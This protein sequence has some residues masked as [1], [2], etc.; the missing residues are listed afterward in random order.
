[1]NAWLI[2]KSALDVV[3]AAEALGVI[4]TATQQAEFTA[5]YTDGDYPGARIM[6]K[7]GNVAQINISG[8]L[9]KEPSWVLRWFGGGNTAYSEII[10]AINEA[11]R[12]PAIEEVVFAIDS[13]GGQTSGLTGAMDAIAAMTMP[14][15]AEV[16]GM[17]ASA[18]YGLASQADSI[19]ATDRGAMFGSIGVKATYYVDG[20]V[21]EVTSSNAP[22]KAPDVTTEEGR[23]MV[24]KL[25]D[26]IEAVF[27]ED[28]ARGRN[29][30]PDKVKADFGRGGVFLAN[31][32]KTHGMIDD[33]KD[34]TQQPGATTTTQEAN[35]M[36]LQELQQKHPETY[37]AA[38]AEGVAQGIAQEKDRVSAH[39]TAGEACGD[40]TIAVAAVN[41]GSQF[42][43]AHQSKYMV[44]GMKNSQIGARQGDTTTTDAALTGVTPGAGV[45]DTSAQDKIFLDALGVQP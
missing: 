9:S 12:D 32:A 16:S 22:E 4:P 40:L 27:I 39:L 3:R 37:A 35:S 17:A 6:S 19:T 11:E 41:D 42:T 29:T 5:S 31:E 30:T 33:V 20:T 43:Q 10:S 26:Q 7:V 15:R 36:N 8:V 18:A 13:P 38:V 1:M 34:R 25:L 44:A 28:I 45:T 2:T 24:Q 14:T 21:I 23:V